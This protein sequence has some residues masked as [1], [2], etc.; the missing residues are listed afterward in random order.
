M[1][2]SRA[3]VR[4]RSSTSRASA[5]S[6]RSAIRATASA[7]RCSRDDGDRA[8]RLTSS[9]RAAAR[10]SPRRVSSFDPPAW[11]SP[12]KLRRLDRHR[13]VRAGGD[14][15]G[16]RRRALP[17]VRGRRRS[18]RRRAGH[19]QRRR[20]VDQRV[21][22]GALPRAD[23]RCAPALLFD[24]TVGQR[25]G[26]PRRPR[27][28]A[29]RSERHDQPQ[30][31]VGLAAM[32]TAVDLLRGGRADAVM[33]GGMDAIYEIFFRAH[34]RFRVMPPRDRSAAPSRRSI[35]AAAASSWA[36][37]ASACGSSEA[38]AGVTRGARG[39]ARSSASVRRAPRVP[40][41]AWPDR[42]EPL[43]RTMAL[44][45]DDAAPDAGRRRRR[46]CV[47]QRDTRARRVEAQRADAA[48]RRAAAVVTSHQGR[49]RRV[50]RVGQRRLRGGAAVRRDG[51]VPPIAGLADVDRRRRDAPARDDRGRRAGPIV[52]VNSFASG[53]AL[54]SP[55]CVRVSRLR[56]LLSSRR[57]ACSD[58]VLRRASTQRPRGGRHRRLARHRPRDR[59]AAG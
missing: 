53:G 19:L 30:G 54:V 24:S 6:R 41:N 55:A 27:V 40:L 47:G 32:V 57:P 2:D 36:K 49:A 59:R 10:C 8:D 56:L 37:A 43:V 45:L 34:D 9:G 39:T 48:V 26:R 52:L 50:R 23:R 38:I 3:A 18:R 1:I 7:T 29:A 4:A 28:Q 17:G 51:R 5:S 35:A 33:A 12:M 21:S 25:R 13:P 31:G 14:P 58:R 44:A 22:R 20:P 11:I 16:D 46:V 15:A 42:P